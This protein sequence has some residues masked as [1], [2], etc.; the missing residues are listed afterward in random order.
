MK[1]TGG[2]QLGGLGL[3]LLCLA[4]GLTTAQ[5]QTGAQVPG[6]ED[7]YVVKR[8]DTLWG[9]ARDL[10]KDPVLWPRIWESNPYITDPNRIYPGDTLALPGR[11]M[12]PQAP[13][14]VA[15]APKPEPPK[16]A[17]KEEAKA[18]APAPPAPPVVPETILTPLPPVPVVSQ[19]GLACSPVLLEESAAFTA[20]VGSILKTPDNRLITSQ[21]DEVIIGLDGAQNPKVGDR[22]AVIRPGMRVIHPWHKRALGRGL[23]T[24]GVLDVTEVRDTALRARVIYGCGAIALG[25][26]VAPFVLAAFPEDKIAQPTTRQVEGV[27]VETPG[28]AELIGLQNVVYL[29]VGTGQGIGPGDVFAVYRP[30][31]PVVNTVTGKE[32]PIP[33]DRLGEAVVIRVTNTTATAVISASGREIRVGDRVVLSRQIQP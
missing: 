20:G 29:D 28:M 6:G 1:R 30:S 17:P 23:F 24:L 16:E 11:E 27:V 26:R 9:I 32:Q 33:P 3:I 31:L 18:P 22:L 25:D 2:G 4:L 5:A 10:L 15:E 12:V 8:G 7:T 21:E 19:R 14:P 13:A